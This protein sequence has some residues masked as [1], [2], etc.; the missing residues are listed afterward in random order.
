MW[1]DLPNKYVNKQGISTLLDYQGW[2]VC[3]LDRSEQIIW[4]YKSYFITTHTCLFQERKKLSAFLHNPIKSL[5][6]LRVFDLIQQHARTG[7][8]Y[9][10]SWDLSQLTFA[11]KQLTPFRQFFIEGAFS[12]LGLV[13]TKF[14][15]VPP[16]LCGITMQ[17]VSTSF[18]ILQYL[19]KGHEN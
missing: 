7:G 8:K 4:K 14:R 3:Y 16:G 17:T 19:C 5:A 10:V 6:S 13:P 12:V 9:G 2:L 18:Y 1:P 11:E 15:I